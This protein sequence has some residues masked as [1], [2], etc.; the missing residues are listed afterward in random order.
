MGA[1]ITVLTLAFVL[2]RVGSGIRNGAMYNPKEDAPAVPH[3]A[4]GGMV[5]V[6]CC[7]F[8]IAVPSGLWSF[9][10]RLYVNLADGAALVLCLLCTILATTYGAT[11]NT[12]LNDLHLWTQGEQM[13]LSVPLLLCGWPGIIALVLATYP[14]VFL[15]KALINRIQ[16]QDMY[17]NGTDDPNGQY[18]SI[19][20]LGIRVP[21][22]TQQFRARV[23]VASVAALAA[24]NIWLWLR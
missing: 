18:Y 23:S 12:W 6:A 11:R 3:L 5:I 17:A 15:Q 22:T 8:A 14:A 19:P 1:T 4:A 21:R 7:L 2:H 10:P 24:L 16:E 9:V 13:L 20:S